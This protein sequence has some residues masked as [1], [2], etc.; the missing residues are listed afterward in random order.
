MRAGKWD[1]RDLWL[2]IGNGS[3]TLSPVNSQS[4]L[5]AS[6]RC[7]ATAKIF[8][9]LSVDRIEPFG[10]NRLRGLVKH[11]KPYGDSDSSKVKTHLVAGRIAACGK[12]V[13]T[14]DVTKQ[15]PEF[16][17]NENLFRTP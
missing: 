14:E 7:S 6:R 2:R 8:A 4:M 15:L 1:I 11:G 16:E 9:A 5:A 3:R 17:S 10:K 13:C 12:L